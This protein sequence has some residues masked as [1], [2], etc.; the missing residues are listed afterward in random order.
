MEETRKIR[1]AIL[2]CSDRASAGNYEDKTGP[3]LKYQIQQGKFAFGRN[4]GKFK[5]SS[6]A[7]KSKN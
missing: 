1:V 2:I 7:E 3:K 6:S 5:M 4:G